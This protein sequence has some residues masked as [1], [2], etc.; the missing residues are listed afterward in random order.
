MNGHLPVV[1]GGHLLD[2]SC[3]SGLA[4]DAA[5]RLGWS[6]TGADA[7]PAMLQRA[8]NR[9]PDVDYRT[10]SLR[11]LGSAFAARFDAMTSVGNALP[12]LTGSQRAVALSQMRA[13]L[14]EGGMRWRRW[15]W[16]LPCWRPAFG[17]PARAACRGGP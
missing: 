9:F 11:S 17:S 12:T 2:A 10:V 4:I 7:S 8:R 15:S 14:H 13:C 3:G 6:V 5:R 1:P 16:R